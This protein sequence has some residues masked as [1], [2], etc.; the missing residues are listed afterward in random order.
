MIYLC[1]GQ[2][3]IYSPAGELIGRID[4]PERPT[5]VVFGGA[6]RSTLYILTHASLYAVKTK[7]PGL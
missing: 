4:V 2:V 1:A 6:D 3:L 5:S 7:I